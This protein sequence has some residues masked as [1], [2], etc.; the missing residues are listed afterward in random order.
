MYEF[1]KGLPR[2]ATQRGASFSSIF[3]YFRPFQLCM[4]TIAIFCFYFPPINGMCLLRL[5]IVTTSISFNLQK[6]AKEY[7]SVMVKEYE[8]V[9]YTRTT[10]TPSDVERQKAGDLEIINHLFQETAIREIRKECI[11]G[12][13]LTISQTRVGENTSSLFLQRSSY[14]IEEDKSCA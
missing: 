8:S 14:W 2:A 9:L 10:R 12:Q 5:L 7:E 4:A 3:I 1:L 13:T 11:S 6:R